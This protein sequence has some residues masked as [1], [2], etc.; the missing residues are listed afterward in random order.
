[1]KLLS[2]EEARQR[3]HTYWKPS[4][5]VE[6]V[7]LSSAVGR[8]LAE[9]LTAPIDVPPFDRS[10][11]DGYAVKAEDTFGANEGEP[12]TLRVMFQV[13]VGSMP[14]RLL[15][16]GEAAYVTT[17]AALPEGANAVIMVEYTHRRGDL[18]QVYKAVAP[19][20]NVLR[21]GSDIAKGSIL[22]TAL[23][24]LTPKEIGLMAAVGINEVPVFKRPI[25]A[26]LSTG[27]ELVETGLPLPL[28]KVYDVNSY[29]L[30]AY[31]EAIGCQYK[32]LGLVPDSFEELSF[33]I[34]EGL[35]DA[36]VVVVS[37]GT[38]K[39]ETDL[40]PSVLSSMGKPGVIVHGLSIKP[41][42]PTVIAV[43][44]GK[45]V[46][47]LPGNPTSALL[48][49]HVLVKPILSSLLGLGVRKPLT[50]KA[51]AAIRMHSAKGRR[52][53]KFVR[54]KRVNNDIYVVP[55]E[56]ESESISTFAKADG[57]VEIPEN[58]ELIEEEETLE[59]YMY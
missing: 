25:V 44:N 59:V 22:L 26:I 2:L 35:K 15:N 32:L 39:G 56:S 46:I 54:L 31:V 36:D 34:R 57:Y 27:P 11:V 50:V 58:V 19:G 24:R 9:D 21:R 6:R 10:K 1:M 53:F 7:P 3:I 16:V 45:L 33:K 38:S 8:V 13:A 23:T 30:M 29:T 37:G 17:G 42:K 49:F 43:V 41:G 18:L 47:G 40:L 28:G 5:K 14:I 4:L 51:K 48:V 20:E 52:E 12:R 55:L